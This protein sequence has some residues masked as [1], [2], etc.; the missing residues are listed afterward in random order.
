MTQPI[1]LS[2]VIPAFNE[3]AHIGRTMRA[4]RTAMERAGIDPNDVVLVDDGSA[5]ATAE[6]AQHA[7]G[8]ELK[9]VTQPNRGR[10]GA[11]RTGIERS[12]RDFVLLLDARVELDPDSLVFWKGQRRTDPDRSVWS[13]HTRTRT[14]GNP[15]AALWQFL[16]ARVWPDYHGKLTGY[17]PEEFDSFP[18]GTGMLIAPRV[19]WLWSIARQAERISDLPQDLVSDDTALLRE[20]I[21]KAGWFWLSPDFG[22][23]YTSSRTTLVS[24]IRN[25]YYRGSTAVDGYAGRVGR[26]GAA[27]AWVP[28]AALAVTPATIAAI[29]FRPVWALGAVCA[30]V[31]LASLATGSLARRSG[32]PWRRSLVVGALSAPFAIGFVPGMWRGWVHRLK[33]RL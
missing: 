30:A 23:W 8:P 14:E 29:M 32:M 19:V 16:A 7:F 15:Y 9:I 6:I 3:A 24:F 28:A 13:G 27:A 18:K 11:R 22:A 1:S 33:K 20:M 2:V 17:G 26:L 21:G 4:L 31:I 5:D 12:S 10:F 25:A